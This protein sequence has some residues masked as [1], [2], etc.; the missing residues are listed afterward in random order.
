MTNM[1]GAL[2]RELSWE[3]QAGACQEGPSNYLSRSYGVFQAGKWHDL[4][5]QNSFSQPHGLF[6]M[7]PDDSKSRK[8]LERFEAPLQTT[9][10]LYGPQRPS[11]PQHMQS[12]EASC[13]FRCSQY[14]SRA[15]THRSAGRRLR[16]VLF[17]FL[18]AHPQ[19]FNFW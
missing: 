10:S 18:L 14:S 1:A 11:S 6:K 3:T 9:L 12:S 5:F 2:G 15:N 19:L 17:C 4:F 16:G 13:H 8:S 7:I